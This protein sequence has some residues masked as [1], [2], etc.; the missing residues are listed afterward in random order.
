MSEEALEAGEAING[1]GVIEPRR[2]MSSTLL[3]P[4]APLSNTFGR[5][6]DRGADRSD[7]DDDDDD[8][9]DDDEEVSSL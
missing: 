1:A 5:Y 2:G 4:G 8:G 9:G 3:R 7:T 6:E